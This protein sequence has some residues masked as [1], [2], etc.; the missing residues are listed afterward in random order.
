MLLQSAA[1][2]MMWAASADSRRIY[3]SRDGRSWRNRETS[4]ARGDIVNASAAGRRAT[5]AGKT[6]LDYTSDGGVSWHTRDVSVG[7][8]SILVSDVAWTLTRDGNLLGVTELVGRGD[9][10]FRSTDPSWRHFVVVPHVHTAFGL[11]RP[12][13]EGHAVVVTDSNGLLIST[14]DGATWHRT[15]RLPGS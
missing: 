13:V 9:V 4:L 6:T 10:L 15:T 7:L 1:E 8:R 3:W 14:D 2:G 11:V 5:L 12:S